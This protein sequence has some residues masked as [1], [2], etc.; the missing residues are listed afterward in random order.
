[1]DGLYYK[2]NDD[3]ISLLRFYGDGLVLDVSIALCK[4]ES[5]GE[6]LTWFNRDSYNPQWSKGNYIVDAKSISFKTTSEYG[7]IDY[8]GYTI[9]SEEIVLHSHSLINDYKAKSNY[10]KYGTNSNDTGIK[11]IEVF[12]ADTHHSSKTINSKSES[13]GLGNLLIVILVILVFL[14]TFGI[15]K[16][17]TVGSFARFI[18]YFTVAG[19]V[20][21]IG[22]MIWSYKK[23]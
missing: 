2:V 10:K 9:S 22:F 21:V 11:S 1:M 12:D 23:K 3:S 7:I 16:W 18:V 8:S 20:L 6:N 13:I 14:A 19:A 17:S 5:I 4:I 15:V